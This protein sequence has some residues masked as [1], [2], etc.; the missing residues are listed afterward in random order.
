LTLDTSL[1]LLGLLG[2]LG[3]LSLALRARL[4]RITPVFCGYIAWC[5][6]NDIL[7]SLLINRYFSS[8]S[9]VYLRIY[10]VEMLLDSAFQFAVLVELGW[11][12]LR[13]IRSSLPRHSILILAAVFAGAGALI[14]PVS[15]RMIPEKVIGPGIFFVHAQ[16][17]VA[18][19]RVVIFVAMAGFS[20]LLSIGWR[21]REFQIAT[22][23][24][25]FSMCSLAISIIHGH[26][27]VAGNPYYH[28]LDQVGVAAYLCSLVYWVFSFAQQE[29][30]RQQFTPEMRNF[31]LA[32]TG[33]GRGTQRPG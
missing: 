9:Q 20:Q 13:P 16:E 17:T 10:L 33:A 32:M 23:L 15:A 30:E 8:F 26:Q 11:A 5:L 12:V 25:F 3:V 27:V 21:N 1:Q 19:L 6:I 31:L 28:R 18:V 22:G 2:D 14:W 4:Y 29:Q 7:F 24:G